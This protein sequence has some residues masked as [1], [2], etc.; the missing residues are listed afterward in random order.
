MW[1]NKE[2]LRGAT[3]LRSFSNHFMALYPDGAR[4]T[5][6]KCEQIERRA[7]AHNVQINWLDI[8]SYLLTDTGYNNLRSAIRVINDE[9]AVEYQAG[10]DASLGRYHTSMAT[11]RRRHNVRVTPTSGPAHDELIAIHARQ[12]RDKN[13]AVLRRSV[14]YARTFG[15]LSSE[16]AQ[17]A[18]KRKPR[19]VPVGDGEVLVTA[20]TL[21][22]LGACDT[23][24]IR[25]GR[26]FPDG[27]VITTDL[28]VK[29]SA[30]FDWNW[31]AHRL[32]APDYGDTWHSDMD[33]LSQK[34]L[35]EQRDQRRE[36][37]EKVEELRRS[38]NRGEISSAEHDVQVAT[39]NARR[40]K[41]NERLRHEYD[42]ASARAFGELYAVHP[43]PI[44]P[45]LSG[46]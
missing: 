1:L 38:L 40:Q 6:K 39:E 34:S 24:V 43:N 42:T 11:W 21:H 17:P 35:Q 19:L 32:L 8:S 7:R 18:F 12:T 9:T 27:A 28:C 20:N 14:R 23:Y 26:H 37:M 2:R 16:Y 22:R 36:H 25:F 46:R 30:I 5:P 4:V 3:Y 15:V 31:A 41:I 29:H 44:L 10:M 13:V 45:T 33:Q